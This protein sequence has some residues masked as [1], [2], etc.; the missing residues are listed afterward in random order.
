MES[1]VDVLLVRSHQLAGEPF[2]GCRAQ[3]RGIEQEEVVRLFRGHITRAIAAIVG[4]RFNAGVRRRHGTAAARQRLTCVVV[5]GI[6]HV[7]DEVRV[8]L[9]RE[10]VGV[11]KDMNGIVD[12]RRWEVRRVRGEMHARRGRELLLAELAAEVRLVLSPLKFTVDR[13]EQADEETDEDE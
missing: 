12:R 3:R 13:A 9:Q 6:V 10:I 8:L 2:V 11:G 7:L 5:I 1:P 4:A